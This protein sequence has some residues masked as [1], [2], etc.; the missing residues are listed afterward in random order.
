[1]ALKDRIMLKRSVIIES[2]NGEVKAFYRIEH[3]RC[4]SFAN[5]HINLVVEF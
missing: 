5:F 2:V 3:S 1:M 4:R